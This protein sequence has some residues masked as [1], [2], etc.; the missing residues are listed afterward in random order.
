MNKGERVAH[1]DVGMGTILSVRNDDRGVPILTIT[2][3]DP[4]QTADGWMVAREWEVLSEF[5]FKMLQLDCALTGKTA[6]EV[7]QQMHHKPKSPVEW[8]SRSDNAWYLS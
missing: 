8:F 5:Q 6:R 2:L 7:A 3:D 4:T 1:L